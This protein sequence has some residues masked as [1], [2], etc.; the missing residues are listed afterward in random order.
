VV[1]LTSSI[2]EKINAIAHQE[3]LGRVVGECAEMAGHLAQFMNPEFHEGPAETSET[4][5]DE[6][7]ARV[8]Y[9]PIC[10]FDKLIT[11]KKEATKP[12]VKG[13]PVGPALPNPKKQG[14]KLSSILVTSS[15]KLVPL[16]IN[17]GGSLTKQERE[18]EKQESMLRERMIHS[19][20]TTVNN[21]PA[22][23]PKVQSFK[24]SK[25]VYD[26]PKQAP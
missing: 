8:A 9:D 4:P 22:D 5:I 14:Q 6:E 24:T 26:F 1:E 7:P 20:L 17:M 16:D 2:Y 11:L 15:P 12:A 19:R 25:L 18:Y 23:V 10:G 3:L 21:S 13:G